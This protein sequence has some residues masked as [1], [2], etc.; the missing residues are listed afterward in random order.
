MK[1]T[2]KE[3][4][5]EKLTDLLAAPKQKKIKRSKNPAERDEWSSWVVCSKG[6]SLALRLCQSG[7]CGRAEWRKRKSTR[8]PRVVV[9]NCRRASHRRLCTNEE[10]NEETVFA[11]MFGVGFIRGY[12]FSNVLI[13]GTKIGV[14][15][16]FFGAI[17]RIF[18]MLLVD[19]TKECLNI[20]H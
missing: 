3:A 20:T 19:T 8:V 18:P 15:Y 2:G 12:S 9:E 11:P 6:W 14:L 17:S 7:S 5:G 13:A 10:D 16:F 4:Y 1:C